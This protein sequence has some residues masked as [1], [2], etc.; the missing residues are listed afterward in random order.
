MIDLKD[1]KDPAFLKD[2][3]IN[4]LNDLAT[5]IRSFIID[6]VAIT[7]GHLSPN[8]GV[9]ELTIAMH[10]VFSSPSDKLIFDV[11]HQ[12]YTHKILT[13]RS[14]AFGTLRKHGGLSG[15]LKREES[16]HDCWEAGH[17]STA[18]A[19]L[20]GYE[21]ARVQNNESHKVV[22][23]VGDGSLNSGLSFEAL[24]FIGHYPKISPAIILND[25]EMSISKNVGTLAKLLNSMRTS[26]PY[27]KAT[28]SRFMPK[29]FNELKIRIGNM[30][31]G[32]AKNMTIFDEFGLQYYGPIDG[33]N[34][35][36]LIKYLE[37]IKNDKH[38][39]VLHVVTKKGKGYPF[40]ECDN[41]GMWHGVDPF[42][43]ETGEATAKVPENTLSWGKLV[44][45]Y[46][47]ERIKRDDFTVIVPAMIN[48][49]GLRDFQDKYPDKIIDVGICESFAVCLS[50]GLA[51]SG[52]TAFVPIYSSFLQRA[53]DQ[54]SHDDA[55]QNLHV[56]FAI[57]RSGIVGGDGETH[58]GIYDIAYLRH[59][60]NIEIVQ[61]AD[62]VELFA[63]L[64]YAFDHTKKPIAIRYPKGLTG[65]L[66]E[67]VAKRPIID[68]PSWTVIKEGKSG[69]LL[70]YGENVKRLEK[71]LA[72]QDLD[73]SLI[74]ARFIKPLDT[75]MLKHLK[76]SNKPLFVM[77]DVTRI[78]GLGSA[79]ME[80]FE[81]LGNTTSDLTIFGLPDQ[82]IGQGTLDEIQ[83][84]FK[85]DP[86][87]ILS[88]ISR[89]LKE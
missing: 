12:A 75:E 56:I 51:Q 65:Y 45:L 74:N 77:E 1:I 39:S 9:V 31:R 33:H 7:G 58:Q 52:K 79:I 40:A 73:V 76:A 46:L 8:L 82:F 22:A 53:Y 14:E 25:N 17:S 28:R 55:R 83:A 88:N 80:Y 2:L 54:V 62:A 89:K 87:T 72:E 44:S 13:G 26:K 47:L 85:L 16:V 50:A 36:T 59:I 32:F 71:A 86:Q 18:L 42:D 61:P 67:K 21:I 20:A 4:E 35:K 23:L 24:N 84:D 19:A 34:I 15:Y 81:E 49:S 37:L 6:N 78:S 3:T 64:D 68:H 60:P 48:G 27:I 5:Q 43:K 69:H 11:G 66:P 70:A 57:D 41:L 38:P 29:L 30:L 63:L 10:R